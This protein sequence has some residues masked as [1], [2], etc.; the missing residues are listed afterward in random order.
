MATVVTLGNMPTSATDVAVKLLDQSKLALQ[1]SQKSP[2]G[3]TVSADYVYADGDYGIETTVS[4]RV[5]SDVKNNVIRTSIR[6]RTIQTVTVDS[7]QTESEPIEV[8]LS[9]NT[10]GR[11][12]DP[13]KVL[14]MIGTAYGLAFNGVTTKVPNEG[15][16][17]KL[18]RSLVAGLYS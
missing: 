13:T 9:W 6:L 4:A 5:Q 17:G 16:I 15:I 11:Y 1:S 2:D 12:E 18:N 10:P 8:I 3:S 7:V 14:A